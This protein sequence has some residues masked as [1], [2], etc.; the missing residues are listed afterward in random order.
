MKQFSL[1]KRL[2]QWQSVL[3]QHRSLVRRFTFFCISWSGTE[4]C[5]HSTQ[6]YHQCSSSCF[7]WVHHPLGAILNRTSHLNFPTTEQFKQSTIESL[8]HLGHK[9]INI[10]KC[11]I[12]QALLTNIQTQ[13][14]QPLSSHISP[15]H[16]L[17]LATQ[18]CECSLLSLEQPSLIFLWK[19]LDS[20]CWQ[21]KYASLKNFTGQLKSKACQPD[22]SMCNS[23]VKSRKVSKIDDESWWERTEPW[24]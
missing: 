6:L 23:A 17:L 21:T 8:F 12:K 22:S 16:V 19:N 9:A 1:H 10:S 15:P 13:T 18:H 5:T 14:L 4:Q 24:S 2:H 3:P 11:G 7:Q 20:K